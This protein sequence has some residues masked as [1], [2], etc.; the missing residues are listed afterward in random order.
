MSRLVRRYRQGSIG[1]RL[2]GVLA[3]FSGAA[4][5]THII[6]R[7]SLPLALATAT[8]AL[9][10]SGI[11]LW[12]R[13]TLAQRAM[14]TRLLKVGAASGLVATVSYDLAKFALSQLDPSPYNPFE[15]VHIF[16]TLLVGQT[17]SDVAIYAA[18][19]AFHLLN[20][21]SFG[22]AY[23]FLF[24]RQGILAGVAW[25]LFLEMFQLTLYPGWLN[26]RFYTEF[27]QISAMSHVVYGLVLGQACRVGLARVQG[28]GP[29]I[30]GAEHGN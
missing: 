16:G 20:G 21:V 18:G 24:R 14:L 19:A 6:W 9:V 5:L 1:S 26:I 2:V 17:S 25:G 3:L 28:A 29:T 8:L 13:A 11:T 15:V 4:L 30:R 10:S 23:C 27:A 7:V 22:V 12:R